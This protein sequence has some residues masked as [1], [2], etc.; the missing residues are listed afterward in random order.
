M[1][2]ITR[3]VNQ[4]VDSA[5]TGSGT[6]AKYSVSVGDGVALTY[7]VTHSLG[8]TDISVT[9]WENSGLLRQSFP[10]VRLI[11]VNTISVIFAVA[12]AADAYRVVVE[13]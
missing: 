2:E 1:I 9:V 7:A 8:T 10:E 3:V 13:G 12:P 4:L 11:D 5:N 6:V